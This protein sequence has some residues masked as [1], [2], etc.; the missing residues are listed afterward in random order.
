MFPII[1]YYTLTVML[2]PLLLLFSRVFR[3]WRLTMSGEQRRHPAFYLCREAWT[4]VYQSVTH[5]LMRKCPEK[6]RW[7]GHWILALGTVMMLTIKVFALR[8]FQTD[9]IYPLYHPQ[10]WLGYLAAGF[11]F[12]GIGDIFIGRL[13]AKKEICKETRFEDLIFPILL[14]LDGAQRS[15][16]THFPLCR[17]RA[18]LSLHIRPA[19]HHRHAHAGGRDAVRKVV[20]HD[21]STAGLVF[22]GGQGEGRAAGA[23]GGGCSPCRSEESQNPPVGAALVVGGGIGG[24]QAALDL[25]N[26]GIK[27]YLAERGPAIGGVMAQ[28]DKTFPTNDCAMCT[29]AP[30]LVEIG[31]H[32]DIEILTLSEVERVDGQPGNFT[33]SI[34]KQPRFVD[35]TKCTGCGACTAECPV[36]LPSEF[37][38]GL[39][40]RKAIYRPFPQA[41]PNIFTISRRGTS[42]CQAGCPIHQSGQGYVTLIAQGRFEEALQVILRDNPIPSICGRVCTHPCTDR[43]HPRHVDDPVNLA[44]VKAFRY[45][46]LSRLQAAA[47]DRARP[48]GKDCHR[49]FRPGRPLCAYQLRQKGYGRRSSKRSPVAGGMLAAGIPSFRLPRP[50][51]NAELDRLRAIGIE[52]MLDTPVGRSITFEELRKSY[53]AVFIAIG[54]HVERKLGIPGENMPGVTGG[55]E[56]LRRVNLGRSG[57]PRPARA[58][59][60]RRKLRSGRGAHRPSLRS[61]QR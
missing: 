23:R 48:S 15:R 26:G 3:I 31:R 2:L 43:L 32:K 53:A 36:T 56:F 47:T 58:G 9:N 38:Q 61:R 35:A 41:V 51:L 14:V 50:L 39:G 6:G 8:W 21:L 29:M 5:S 34:K 37:D 40:E 17:L 1:T 42:P 46:P 55:V 20:A 30:R 45:R 24:M 60:W 10:R 12:Y 49:G 28:L 22:P 7:L 25:A 4:Y 18:Y 13:R 54:A 57:D 52:I 16:G 27:V 59:G 33:V 11:I 19:H 44:G